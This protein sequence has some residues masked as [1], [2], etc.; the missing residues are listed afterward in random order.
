MLIST[1]TFD[2]SLLWLI[3]LRRLSVNLPTRSSSSRHSVDHK[4]LKKRHHC[5]IPNRR[6]YSHIVAV[7]VGIKGREEEKEEKEEEEEEEEKE[8]EEEEEEDTT[9]AVSTL[10]AA[11]WTVG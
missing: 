5:P 4:K 11:M 1:N 9:L 6:H 7:A 10:V 3:P 2:C 8:E